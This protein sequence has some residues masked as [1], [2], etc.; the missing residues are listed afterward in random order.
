MAITRK[1]KALPRMAA[2]LV[3]AALS[4]CSTTD[5]PSAG[6][7]PTRRDTSTLPATP[8]CSP[9]R[10]PAIPLP[11]AWRE[12]ALS[13]AGAVLNGGQIL[14]AISAGY[15]EANYAILHAV[16]P[17]CAS[18]TGFGDSGAERLTYP[19]GTV[20]FTTAIASR[21][22]GAL[23]GGET[24]RGWLVAKI[25]AAGALDTS[26]G[27]GGWAVLPWAGS[28]SVLV[29][30]PSGRILVGGSDG[31]GCCVRAWVGEVTPS[32]QI[33]KG[34]GT[35]GRSVVPIGV[36]PDS[37]VSRVVRTADGAI[38]VLNSGGNMGC[39]GVSVSKF[40]ASGVLVRS[41]ERR[42][43]AAMKKLVP[44][45]VF[46]ADL[47][48]RPHGF[49]LL[50][51]TQPD[52]VTDKPHPRAHGLI[53]SFGPDG[54]LEPA[55][56]EQGQVRFAAQMAQ[57]AGALPQRDGTT[58]LV[59]QQVSIAHDNEPA[60]L[61]LIDL[62]ANGQPAWTYGKEG[63]QRIALPFRNSDFPANALP[64]SVET[65]GHLN[66]VIASDAKGENLELHYPESQTR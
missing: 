28:A 51:A 52:C 34:F 21:D 56:G 59:L 32:G 35:N 16:T 8:T 58:L 62:F 44:L 53:A 1:S 64:V 3:A 18:A 63:G 48:P 49:L 23:L 19:R 47:V 25:N 37:G 65:D 2:L 40:T 14:V 31:G 24:S 60:T 27:A 38:Y 42:F 7:S 10:G 4:A 43:T 54:E 61:T 33:V 29:E 5:R 55:F 15:P 11:P 12:A 41:F 57:S 6:P 22:G 30:T 66:V 17:G 20:Q 46:V 45:G 39:W 13:V 26:F 9:G 36:G 50:G